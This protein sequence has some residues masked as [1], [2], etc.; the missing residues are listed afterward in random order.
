MVAELVKIRVD[1]VADCIMGKES[2]ALRYKLL[3]FSVRDDLY[4]VA[5]S[6]TSE[7]QTD[8]PKRARYHMPH[9]MRP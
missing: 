5:T 1:T 8:D 6:K 9:E 4:A 3:I 7:S 2:R